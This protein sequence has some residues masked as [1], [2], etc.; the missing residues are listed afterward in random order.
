MERAWEK[1]WRPTKGPRRFVTHM[2]D[3]IIGT[4]VLD[5]LCFVFKGKERGLSS[6]EIKQTIPTQDF[7]PPEDIKNAFFSAMEG[8]PYK[9]PPLSLPKLKPFKARVLNAIRSIPFGSTLTY[10]DVATYIGNPNAARAV[11]QVMALNP[12][13]IFFP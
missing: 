7:K 12:I 13:P 2:E 1:L 8:R 4:I 3:H 5:D 10:K 6:I 11:G 9:L